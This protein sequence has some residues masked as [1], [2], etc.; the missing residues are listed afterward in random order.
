M[1]KRLLYLF[2]FTAL[3]IMGACKK[4]SSSNSGNAITGNWKFISVSAVTQAIVQTSDGVSAYKT[5]TNSAYTSTNN[6]GTVTIA[7]NT[8]TANGIA[9]NITDTAYASD[10]QDNVLI[11]TFSQ[12]FTFNFPASNSV[13][14]YNLINSDSVYFTG[15]GIF[16]AP[17]VTGSTPTGARLA[18]NGNILTMT[19][20]VVKDSTFVNGGYPAS[21][22]ETAN[23]VSTLQRQ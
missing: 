14:S 18:L 7:S 11:D 15:Q 4:D 20:S 12:V 8:M 5:I 17:G 10:Y 13:S 1:R 6:T 19:S 3:L 23:V 22:H 21:N 9:Y 2:S 16:S